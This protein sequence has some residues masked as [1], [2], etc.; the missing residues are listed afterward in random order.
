M[1]YKVILSMQAIKHVSILRRNEPNSYK[2]IKRLLKELENHPKTVTGKPE[3]L[4]GDRSGQ[5][6]RRISKKHRLIYTIND[7]IVEVYVISSYGHYDD[8]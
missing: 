4:K 8:K 6:S 2:K 1:K 3:R 7:D 5:W